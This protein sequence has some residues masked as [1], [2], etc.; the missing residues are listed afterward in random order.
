MI[1]FSQVSEGTNQMFASN[2]PPLLKESMAHFAAFTDHPAFEVMEEMGDRR[3]LDGWID[4]AVHC[5]PVP[6]AELLFPLPDVFISRYAED[7]DLEAARNCIDRF[8]AALNDFY[9]DADVETF[10]EKHRAVYDGVL[11]EVRK[12][13]PPKDFA[14]TMESY[15]G[16]EKAGFML[17]PSPLM[18]DGFGFGHQVET[19]EGM[20]VLNV[21]GPKVRIETM[22]DSVFGFDDAEGIERVSVHEFGHSF[23]NPLVDLPE[24]RKI[25]DS[26][27]HLFEPVRGAMSRSGYRTW[28]VT[29]KE[30]I[31]RLGEVRIALAMGDEERAN[32]IRDY[33]INERKFIY[34][35][36]LEESIRVYEQNRDR[37]PSLADYFPVLLD[38]F[39][40]VDLSKIQL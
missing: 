4:I 13:L 22:T 5:T 35:P 20:R 8:I 32:R 18:Y 19:K 15:Y 14:E 21:F 26:Y 9:R 40:N 1:L 30:L 28:E 29:V 16:E 34:L 27:V 37:Y 36:I 2:I 38:A 31:V 33:Q 3:W 17:I 7:G 39:G 12:N 11:D 6:H 24:N 25:V 10:F 23:V